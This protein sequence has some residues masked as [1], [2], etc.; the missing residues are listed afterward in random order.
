M[1]E[2][3]QGA[4]LTETQA[5]LAAEVLEASRVDL[6]A[7]VLVEVALAEAVVPEAAEEAEVSR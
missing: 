3:A 5:H 1:E 7:A 2:E 4:E 6:G